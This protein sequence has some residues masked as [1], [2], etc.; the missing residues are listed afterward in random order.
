MNTIAIIGAG[1]GGL[2]CARMLQQHGIGVTIYDADASAAARDAGGSLDLHADAAQIALADA[3]LL[4]A[5]M[6]VARLEDQAKRAM[7]RHA[8]VRG[9]F[10]PDDDD[11]AA[12]EIDRGQ[13]R[14]LIAAHVRP[15]AVRWGH[16]LTEATPVSGGRYR[17]DFANGVTTEADL[18]IGADGMW[19]RVRRLLT[20]ALPQYSGVSF[21]DVRY[22]DADRRHA[23]LAELVGRGHLFAR[24]DD[25]S[26]IIAQRNS[27]GVIRGYVAMRADAD[28]AAQA[29]V[30]VDDLPA[31]HAYLLDRF[32][33][34]SPKLLAFLT[35]SDEYVERA[36]WFLP[37]PLTWEHNPGMTLLGDAA[38]GMGP[39]GGHGV[40]LALLDA[41]ELAHA[42]A[43]Q[44][45][46]D[47][48]VRRY[49]PTM[50]SR[51][52][53]LAQASNAATRAF[54]GIGVSDGPH[55]IPDHGTTHRRY[56]EDAVRYRTRV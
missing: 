4:D 16:K 11:T 17:L 31:L 3:G 55:E 19:S 9:T 14:A 18:V 29:G 47:A 2:L 44:P 12:P 13:L 37:A 40:N 30:S 56:E 5:C 42:I 23:A 22:D 41:V 7:D 38:H 33:G 54:F 20:D 21:L 51:A 8:N 50:W 43:S 48:A 49:E 36:I 24:G 39:F 6:A 53:G 15:E 32:A 1:P 26:A 28:W 52:A 10:V 45:T 27:N 46:L 34:W 25:G 35:D